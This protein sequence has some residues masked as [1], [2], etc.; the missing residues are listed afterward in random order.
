MS[1]SRG[2]WTD[3]FVRRPVLAITI[4]LLVAILGLFSFFSLKT[5]EYPNLTNTVIK[6]STSYSGA[7]PQTVQSFITQPLGRVL[8]QTPD[9]DYL[10]SSSSQ[11]SST[12]TLYMKLNSSQAKALGNVQT[13]ITQ[14]QDQLPA[15]SH[16]PVVNVSSGHQTSLMYM[17]F[18]SPGKV[19]SPAQI[20]DYVVRNVQPLLQTVSGVS[21]ARIIPGGSGGNG[22][23]LAM[24]VWLN[25]EAMT[26]YGVTSAD[27][28]QTLEN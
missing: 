23:T 10:T 2:R 6:V 27:V 22:N 14:V 5:R 12:L 20:T 3:L 8:G 25:P 15:N 9:L 24:R 4:A 11:G 7:S 1:E 21:Q 28:E 16:P 17:A 19:M 13:E 26:A 18:Y